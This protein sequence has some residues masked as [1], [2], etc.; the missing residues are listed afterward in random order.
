[1]INAMEDEVIPK[2]CTEKLADA[3]AI[4][5][6][7][8]WLDG[9]GHYTSMAEL[10]TSL[11]ITAD[12]FAR[13]LPPGVTPPGTAARTN[14]MKKLAE[15]LRQAATML[16]G[17]PGPGKSFSISLHYAFAI[18]KQPPLEGE[19]RFLRDSQNRFVLSCNLPVVGKL[20]FGQGEYPWM[21]SGG[22][23]LAGAENPAPALKNPQEFLG[24]QPR[25]LLRMLAGILESVAQNP[26]VLLRYIDK[27]SVVPGEKG[28]R[29][30]VL[31]G[32]DKKF[33][34]VEMTFDN[35]ARM[36]S[37]VAIRA[38]KFSGSIRIL[39]WQTDAP[40]RPELFAPPADLP[41][42]KVEQRDVYRMFESLRNILIMAGG[43]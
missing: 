23:V 42:K 4:P 1:M 14:E 16:A 22:A 18:Q 40:S 5:D 25:Q 39:D 7:I 33:G 6:K 43:K 37:T 21:V 10:P 30:L 38:E 31:D 24:K 13:D 34:D 12:F 17:T 28:E 29:K 3:L 26:E 2:R 19:F 36:P 8:I 15:I 41:V 27:I 9:L 20:S 35:N 32:K 11:K